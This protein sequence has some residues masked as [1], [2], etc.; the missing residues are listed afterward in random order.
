MSP[1]ASSSDSRLSIQPVNDAA[2]WEAFEELLRH[3]ASNDLG[4]A[5]SSSIW[6]DLKDLPARY[7]NSAGGGAALA[8]V[9]GTPVG[10]GAFA[11]TSEQSLC[12]LKR[13]YVLPA[14]RRLGYG[15]SLVLAMQ[16]S[17][18][19]Y[20]YLQAGLSVW[21]DN[22]SSLALYRALGFAPIPA[23]KSHPDPTLLF[24]GRALSNSSI[25]E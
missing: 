18:S 13:F 10:C 5:A 14:W 22:S 16:R 8:L 20:G 23:F 11:A 3:Y 1:A 7:S 2:E 25:F 4:Q 12:E 19:A 24:L 21:P 9:E 6:T 17:A 15:R